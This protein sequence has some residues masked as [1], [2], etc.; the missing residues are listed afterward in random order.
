MPREVSP[1]LPKTVGLI[2]LFSNLLT[3]C[4]VILSSHSEPVTITYVVLANSWEGDHEADYLLLAK[5][6]QEA[7]PQINVDVKIVDLGQLPMGLSQADFMTDPEWG[8]DVVIADA[9]LFEE[10]VVHNDHINDFFTKEK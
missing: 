2:L 9:Y 10:E 8:V 4:S 7:H 3:A 5:V 1:I 6:F